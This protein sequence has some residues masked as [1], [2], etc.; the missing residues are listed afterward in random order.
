MNFSLIK[1]AKPVQVADVK[2]RPMPVSTSVMNA[3][4]S[5]GLA[6]VHLVPLKVLLK[7][8]IEIGISGGKETR[9]KEKGPLVQKLKA[10]NLPT[11][12][13]LLNMV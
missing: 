10:R 4:P 9:E 8:E 13:N 5:A 12:E 6:D 1:S 2:C 3:F 7:E 11:L